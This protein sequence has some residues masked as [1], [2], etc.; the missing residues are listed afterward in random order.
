MIKKILFFSTYLVSVGAAGG[1]HYDR[2]MLSALG[3]DTQAADLLD[4]GIHF[5]P[6]EHPTHIVVNGQSKGLHRITFGQAGVPCWSAVQ[7]RKLGIDPR[8]FN[9]VDPTCLTPSPGSNIRVTEQV[10]RSSLELQIPA[11]SLLSD[12][13]YATGGRALMVNYD[14]RH[15]AWQTRSGGDRGAQTLT[16]EVGANINNWIIRSGQSYTRQDTQRHFT[17]LYTWGQRAIPGWA[18]V[19]QIGEIT[20][21]DPLFS[22]IAL[23]GAQIVPERALQNGGGNRVSLDILLSRAGTAEVWQGN[24]LL[25]TFPVTAGMN[26]L[27]G[28]P[29]LNPQ[30]DFVVI[31]HDETGSRQQQTIP[32]IQARPY[33]AMMITGTSL[34]VGQLRLARQ[35]WPLLSGSTGV[36]HSQNLAVA[37]GG[38]VAETRQAVS[39]RASMRLTERLLATLSQTG[40]QARDGGKRKG[41][42]HQLGLGYPVTQRLSLS[43]SANFRSRDYVEAG[44]AWS[45]PNGTGQVKAQYAAGLNYSQPWLGAF[46]FS[47]SLSQTRQG[48]ETMGYTLGWGRAFGNVNLNLGVQKN[49]LADD[50]GR[51][52]THYASLNI[53]IPLGPDRS[54]RSWVSHDGERTRAG[55]GYDQTLS[56]KFAWSLSGEKDQ[57]QASSIASSAIWTNKYSQLSGGVARSDSGSRYNMGARGGAVLHDE[58]LTFTPRKV[59]DTFGVI[60]LNGPRPDVEIRTPAGKVWS[61]DSGHA[62]ASW[63]PWQKNTLQVNNHSL[64]KNVQVLSGIADVTPWRGSVVPVSIPAFTVRRAL[65]TF[66]PGEGPTAGSAVKNTRGDLVAFVNEDGSLFFDDL[67]DGPLFGQLQDGTRCSIKLTS[68]WVADPGSLYASLSARCVL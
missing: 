49:R 18:S 7:L 33:N 29:A 46:S 10:E 37:A 62:I 11:N 47:G 55:V 8:S 15:Y 35:D 57:Q 66:P 53:A 61:D 5:L 3:Y 51:H 45:A 44:S 34:A 64:A 16:S 25:K 60:S 30:D 19:L 9:E 50:S 38:L 40:T 54:L 32:W 26:R 42:S 4:S 20:T 12:V 68:P 36:Y 65:V 1:N 67:P 52:D 6:G 27:E 31:S 22:G 28:I 21:E 14:G 63:T 58:G 56:D 43:A 59:G 39:W 13:Q 23:T 24:I 48:A 41:F 17:R 2:E